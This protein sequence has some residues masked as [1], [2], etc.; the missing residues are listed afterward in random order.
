MG[1]DELIGN[2]KIKKILHSYILNKRIPF[3]LIFY[4]P[5]NSDLNKFAVSFSKAVNCAK[6]DGDFCDECN[7]CKEIS[8]GIYP[9]VNIV[10]PE[11]QFYKKDQIVYLIEDNSKRPLKS[12]K[13]VYIV[14]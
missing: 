2:E 6:L 8:K 13:K 3:S 14:K 9:D 12:E 11:G 1:F 5:D 7:N 4:G 10:Y